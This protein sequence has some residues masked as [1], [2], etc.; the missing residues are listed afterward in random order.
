MVNSE[1]ITVQF[2]VNDLKI[3]HKEQFVLEDS[4][5]DLRSEFGQ[6][7]KL[8]ENTGLKLYVLSSLL[9]CECFLARAHDLNLKLVS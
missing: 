4:L 6:E 1:Q 5:S 7:D 9:S 2:H 3:S 8:T